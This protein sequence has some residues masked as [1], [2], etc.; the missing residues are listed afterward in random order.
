M[1]RFNKF[2]EAATR[3]LDEAMEKA[4][5]EYITTGEIKPKRKLPRNRPCLIKEKR[6]E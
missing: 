3:Q 1:I 2:M 6:D 4:L 5:C